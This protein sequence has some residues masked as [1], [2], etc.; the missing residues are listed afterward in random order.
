LCDVV[1]MVDWS[2]SGFFKESRLPNWR[3]R[4]ARAGSCRQAGQLRLL[5]SWRGIGLQ[6]G[7]GGES[8]KVGTGFL[9]V[10]ETAEC[11]SAWLRLITTKPDISR[12]TSDCPK[13]QLLLP[14]PSTS[15]SIPQIHLLHYAPRSIVSPRPLLLASRLFLDCLFPI[16]P[17]CPA[18]NASA[19]PQVLPC[20]LLSA[21][22]PDTLLA[23]PP[24]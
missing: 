22:L 4:Y 9:D 1:Q 15:T 16:F 3:R 21:P 6:F 8:R 14:L 11:S 2:V 12:P 18:V 7:Q 24:L 19:W 5:T 13:H 17:P 23:L 20:A 10:A